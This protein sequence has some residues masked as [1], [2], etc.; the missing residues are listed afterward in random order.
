MKGH[1]TKQ[2]ETLKLDRKTLSK[3]MLQYRNSLLCQQASSL[4][5]NIV[6]TQDNGLMHGFK[7][8]KWRSQCTLVACMF[9]WVFTI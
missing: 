6:K 7:C 5:I 9:V 4:T 8:I 3:R 1:H 2:L